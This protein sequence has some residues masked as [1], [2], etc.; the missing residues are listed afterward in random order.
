MMLKPSMVSCSMW[1]RDALPALEEEEFYHSDLIGLD[2]RLEDGSVIGSIV[3]IHDFGAG[4]L[5][6][7]VP[8]RGKGIYIPFTQEA[9][10]QIHMS[11]G[12]VTVVP[13]EGLLEEVD[14][15]ERAKEGKAA[16]FSNSPELLEGL[17]KD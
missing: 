17:K 8:A 12:Y 11:Q 16:D 15:A 3:A 2:A 1:T 10:P 9:V 7:V 14:D 13:P 6:D 5:L 4:D